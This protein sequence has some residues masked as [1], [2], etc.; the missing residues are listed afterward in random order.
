MR[1]LRVD[2][3]GSGVGPWHLRDASQGAPLRA[4]RRRTPTDAPRVAFSGYSAAAHPM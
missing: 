1:G 3:D 2:R 4:V